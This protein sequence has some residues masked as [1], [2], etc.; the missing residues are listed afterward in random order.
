M[1]NDN[2]IQFFCVLTSFFPWLYEIPS[3]AIFIPQPRKNV[4]YSYN[5]KHLQVVQFS[6]S[7]APA[8]AWDI[9]DKMFIGPYTQCQHVT[10]LS[11]M[12]SNRKYRVVSTCSSWSVL[13]IEQCYYTGLLTASQ[14]TVTN[15]KR[16]V[17]LLAWLCRVHLKT[18]RAGYTQFCWLCQGGSKHG[19]RTFGIFCEDCYARDI[20]RFVC[21][22]CLE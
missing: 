13:F 16:W 21:N 5:N 12:L 18:W 2:L 20:L 7:L 17:V 6:S 8:A 3:F 14:R 15:V 4:M 1:L 19:R 9:K 11:L 10:F 22:I